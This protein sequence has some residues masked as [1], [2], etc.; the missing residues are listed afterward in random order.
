MFPSHDPFA[1]PTSSTI[2]EGENS[3]LTLE[4]ND[5]TYGDITASIILTGTMDPVSELT[6]DGLNFSLQ[7]SDYI[8][9]A[10]FADGVGSYSFAVTASDDVVDESL[11]SA[12]FSISS[13]EFNLSSSLFFPSAAIGANSEF[14]LFVTDNESGSFRINNL[15]GY[16][17]YTASMSVT[18][19]VER[20]NAADGIATATIDLINNDGYSKAV[21]GV[22]Y[23]GSSGSFPY[24]FTWA[25]Q[26]SGAKSFS[27]STLA[28]S[29]LT[30]TSITPKIV[31]MSSS[32]GTP[33][34]ASQVSS[35]AW[36]TH[37]GELYFL[38][39]PIVTGKLT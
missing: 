31:S 12:S 19:S 27:I 11:E 9:T 6:I 36:I 5:G 37:P 2:I 38:C 3:L 16:Y 34:T 10:T 35:S 29:E 4:R 30:G 24:S 20:I 33:M 17:F 8:A 23:T 26:E 18:W 13:L 21:F 1:S 7:G 39:R 32:F 15:D 22:D 28:N 14:T 25:D